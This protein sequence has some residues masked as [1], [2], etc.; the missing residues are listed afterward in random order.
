M[1]VF[2][3]PCFQLFWPI[4]DCLSFNSIRFWNRESIKQKAECQSDLENI[5]SKHIIVYVHKKTQEKL[6]F[7][8]GFVEQKLRKYKKE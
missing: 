2:K 5:S 7:I 1:Q 8:M 6:H 4:L 3:R